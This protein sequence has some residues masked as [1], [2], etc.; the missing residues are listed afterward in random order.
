M[1]TGGSRGLGLDIARELA[2][3]GAIVLLI[4]RDHEE[5]ERARAR[6][7]E[8]TGG[9]VEF[10]S[11]DVSD[12]DEARSAMLE[13]YA[14]YRRIDA[15]FN[16]AGIMQ[17]GPL[18]EMTRQDFQRAMEVNVWGALNLTMAAVPHMQEGRIVN[19]ASI[20]GRI[21]MPHLAPYTTSKFAMVGLSDAMRA[22]LRVRGI[23]V[24][25][26]C[27]G[28]M[29]TGSPL[30]AE[31]RGRPTSEYRWFAAL[32]GAPFLSMSATRAARR[33][34]DAMVHGDT[35]LTLGVPA[36]AAEIAEGLAPGLTAEIA[37][38]VERML[39][40]TP[41]SPIYTPPVSGAEAR[42]EDP[43]PLQR[44]AEAPAAE[45]NQLGDDVPE[46]RQGA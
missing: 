5:L 18:E 46:P 42:P 12:Y 30:H 28:L 2:R 34:V 31:F 19:I 3:G 13:I 41:E 17:V 44:R 21:A 27:P 45:H 40:K 22:E 35:H 23:R 26:V 36:R 7:S 43:G 10:I 16:V 9:R 25:T 4:A 39:P 37:A 6:L 24:T 11:A 32:S 38:A 1:V 20:G 15:V 29:R 33:I 8:E 14:R